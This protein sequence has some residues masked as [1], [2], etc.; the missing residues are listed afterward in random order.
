[1]KNLPLGQS[2]HG[3]D[4]QGMLI[5]INSSTVD[6]CRLCNKNTHP[7]EGDHTWLITGK[8]LHTIS[9]FCC[10]SCCISLLCWESLNWWM[11]SQSTVTAKRSGVITVLVLITQCDTVENWRNATWKWWHISTRQTGHIVL[12]TNSAWKGLPFQCMRR[13]MSNLTSFFFV[14][15]DKKC[16]TLPA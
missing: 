10:V 13:A 1:M 4:L 14:K 9:V 16:V 2:P 11:S 6:L 3:C 5:Y 15:L 7:Y 8:K 12:E